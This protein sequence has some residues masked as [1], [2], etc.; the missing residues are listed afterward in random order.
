MA[1]ARTYS[2]ILKL[3]REEKGLFHCK[4][5][6]SQEVVQ[7]S[8]SVPS[9][10]QIR[11]RV[12]CPAGHE[13]EIT[14]VNA[15]RQMPTYHPKSTGTVLTKISGVTY[16]NSD[17]VQRQALLHHVRPG[18]QLSV[19]KGNVNGK[20]VFLVKHA[21]GVIGTLRSDVLLPLIP[22]SDL[23]CVAGKVVKTTGGWR[24]KPTLG[25]NI[26]LYRVE[27]EKTVYVDIKSQ[28]PIYHASPACSGMTDPMA[29]SLEK[30]TTILHAKPCKHCV[31]KKEGN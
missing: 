17:G 2:S 18:D 7:A 4:T 11:I 21:L 27:P 20:E 3:A 23:G 15:N 24:E 19:I 16:S 22:D 9:F 10:N 26:E 6:G 14:Y 8:M 5:C 31:Q 1:D 30:A 12:R 28:T 29:M 25:C 13:T